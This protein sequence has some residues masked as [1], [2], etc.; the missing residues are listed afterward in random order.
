[1][2][3]LFP[4]VID[5][6][7]FNLLHLSYGYKLLSNATLGEDDVASTEVQIT[8][9]VNLRSPLG[10]RVSVKGSL[11]VGGKPLMEMTSSFLFRYLLIH[12]VLPLLTKSRGEFTDFE[13]TF[14]VSQVQKEVFVKEAKDKAILTSK[15]WFTKES[16]TDFVVGDYLRFEVETEERSLDGQVNY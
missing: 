9:I 3:T 8:E 16:N 5:A 12:S 4:S 11:S 1:M 7:L 2:K 13:N 14:R 10:K 6:D 15:Q